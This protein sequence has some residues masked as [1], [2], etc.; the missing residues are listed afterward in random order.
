MRAGNSSE[1]LLSG[2]QPNR[3]RAPWPGEMPGGVPAG[4][5]DLDEIDRQ[6]VR[7]LAQDARL[8]NNALA[9]RGGIAPS[10]RPRRGGPL[11]ARGGSDPRLPRR[12]GPGR[13]RAAASG[14]DRGPAAG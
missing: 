14:D 3:V 5:G 6:I 11:A 7:E 13:P 1:T 10:T 12:R 2:S 8:A 4:A 9:E